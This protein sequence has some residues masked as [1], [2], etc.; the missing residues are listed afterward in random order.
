MVQFELTRPRHRTFVCFELLGKVSF[1]FPGLSKPRAL[2]ADSPCGEP[3][4]RGEVV[5]S[6]HK[7]Q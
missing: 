5:L 1:L 6:N 3:L 7:G 2:A 4:T